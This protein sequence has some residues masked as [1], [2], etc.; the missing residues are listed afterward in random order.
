MQCIQAIIIILSIFFVMLCPLLIKLNNLALLEDA[1]ERCTP[2]V[3][4]ST[5]IC[6]LAES[7]L[8]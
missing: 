1:C 3:I 2:V 8:C 4:L 7:Q 6:C 5:V